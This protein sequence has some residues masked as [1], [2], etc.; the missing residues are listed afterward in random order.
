MELHAAT[1][2]PTVQSSQP[3]AQT[4][5]TV[6]QSMPPGVTE[7]VSGER[8]EFTVRE[9][10]T[11]LGTNRQY[12]VVKTIRSKEELTR[13]GIVEVPEQMDDVYFQQHV[14]FIVQLEEPSGSHLLKVAEV[15][16]SA[17]QVTIFIQRII[18]EP[19]WTADMAW[20]SF[21]IEIDND[22]YSG[23]EVLATVFE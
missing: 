23:A 11:K 8:I 4:A 10:H 14:L 15:V 13:S 19:P 16:K 18:P 17:D 12:S 1:A 22:E 21:L 20:W 2:R 5:S 7:S 9:I 6:M 3:S